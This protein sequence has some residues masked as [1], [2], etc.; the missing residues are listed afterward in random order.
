MV[1]RLFWIGPLTCLVGAALQVA[2]PQLKKPPHEDARPLHASDIA[3]SAVAAGR[4]S[5]LNTSTSLKPGGN[6][7]FL[8]LTM[9]GISDW[10]I[11]NQFL[12]VADRA[13]TKSLCT[14]KIL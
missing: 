6:V 11:W 3:A 2:G 12:Q 1:K 10:E 5:F 4:S 13:D 14:A 8:F 9:N 7:F